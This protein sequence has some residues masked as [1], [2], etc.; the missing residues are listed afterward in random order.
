MT[1]LHGDIFNIQINF[2]LLTIDYNIYIICEMLFII[3]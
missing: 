3:N 1:N 2:L